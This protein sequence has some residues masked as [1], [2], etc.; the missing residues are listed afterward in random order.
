MT[1]FIRASRAL[2]VITTVE[3]STVSGVSVERWDTVSGVSVGWESVSVCVVV[4][5]GIGISLGLSLTLGDL[6]DDTGGRAGVV[7]G[8]SLVC[9]GGND[10][11]GVSNSLGDVVDGWDNVGS[12]NWSWVGNSSWGICSSFFRLLLLLLNIKKYFSIQILYT[13]KCL[14]LKA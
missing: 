12:W 13:V 7:A 9:D 6:V 11:G 3:G 10:G 14:N 2:V 4:V 8:D 5:G 1:H